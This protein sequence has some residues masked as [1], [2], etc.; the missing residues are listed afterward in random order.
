MAIFEHDGIAFDY[1]DRGAGAPFIF[2]HGL[3]ADRN[4]PV[5]LA[6]DEAARRLV[7]MSCR[8]HGGTAPLGD[9]EHLSIPRFADDVAALAAHLRLG[10]STAGGIS[11]GAAVALRLAHRHP[12]MVERL[13]LVRPA[14]LTAPAPAHLAVLL[15]VARHLREAGP[16]GLPAFMREPAYRAVEA[17]SPDNAAS[18]R[19]QFEADDPLRRATVLERI[20]AGEPG[21]G[22]ADLARLRLPVLVIANGEDPM[23]PVDLARALAGRLP[24]AELRLVTSKSIDPQRHV[25]EVREALRDFV[26]GASR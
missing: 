7:A 6:G 1:A 23:H 4:Q 25:V 15:V 16:E 26:A 14:W 19:R 5:E 9:P 13:V 24:Q 17:Q 3:S 8:G 11:M 10:R 18:L 12:A 2:Q 21:I 22:D 20:V